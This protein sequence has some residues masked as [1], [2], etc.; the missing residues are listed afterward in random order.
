MDL[1]ESGSANMLP[2]ARVERMVNL[3][4]FV[5]YLV[6]GKYLSEE[7]WIVGIEFG[8]EII[9]GEGRWRISQYLLEPGGSLP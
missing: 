1:L 4:D 8:S 7:D 6:Q 2:W 9:E 3:G 5:Q